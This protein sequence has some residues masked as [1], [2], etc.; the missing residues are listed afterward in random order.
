MISKK[1]KHFVDDLSNK[2][3]KDLELFFQILGILE[4]YNIE[5]KQPVTYQQI[6]EIL[7]N[8]NP[9]KNLKDFNRQIQGTREI[10]NKLL[11]NFSIKGSKKGLKFENVINSEV[12]KLK[13]DKGY[14]TIFLL[15]ISF[16]LYKSE[17]ELELLDQFLEQ[18]LPFSFLI[19]LSFSIKNSYSIDFDYH[20]DRRDETLHLEEFYPKKIYFKDN[21]WLLIGFDSNKNQFVQFLIHSISNLS[22]NQKRNLKIPKFNFAKFRKDS[23]SLAV[24]FDTKPIHFEIYVPKRFVKSVQ[25]RRKEGSW[26]HK[27]D[28]SIWKLVTYDSSEVFQY[29]FRWRGELRILS[30]SDSI[31]EFKNLL[32]EIYKIH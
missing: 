20:S 16:L 5:R 25:K 11:K 31:K 13:N 29:I 28:H 4:F 14:Q 22:L 15:Y 17:I 21:H 12:S 30:P 8:L 1:K 7:D 3:F 27:S 32:N 24:L 18:E 26:I 10:I 23:F 19:H 2:S 6:S 9:E